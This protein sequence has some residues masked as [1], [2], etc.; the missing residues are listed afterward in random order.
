[1][2]SALGHDTSKL[3]RSDKEEWMSYAKF[4]TTILGESAPTNPPAYIQAD[5]RNEN[6]LNELVQVSDVAGMSPS[7]LHM[8]GAN[9]INAS[10]AF[11]LVPTAQN[12]IIGK[13]LS[14]EWWVKAIH[15]YLPTKKGSSSNSAIGEE[16]YLLSHSEGFNFKNKL[17]KASDFSSKYGIDNSKVSSK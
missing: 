15:V 12:A 1:M 13:K 9:G 10:Y 3:T 8:H 5:T 14:D 7:Y 2:A 16:Y 17:I 6:T 11:D 4:K